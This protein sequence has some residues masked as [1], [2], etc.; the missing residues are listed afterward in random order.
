MGK[1]ISIVNQKGGVGKTITSINLA[2]A[3][4]AIEKKT[5]IIDADPQGNATTGIAIHKKDEN[6]LYTIIIENDSVEDAII[7]SS[8]EFLDILPSHIDL[9]A[10]EMELVNINNF[11]YR[12]RDKIRSVVDKY[13]YIIID[14][15]PSLGLL[16]INALTASD[17]VIIPLQ[18]EF[19]ALEGLKHLM[20]TIKMVKTNLNRDL[21]I[22]GVLLTMYDKR[23]NL[24]EQVEEDVRSC[25]GDLVYTT[26]IP[27]NVKMSEASSY[28]KPAL[29]YDMHCA[30]SKAY[31]EM[32]KEFL[33]REKIKT[34]ERI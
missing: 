28:G 1:V 26:I 30:G 16:T 19:F 23:N 29:V 11:R 14:C 15:P 33:N 34:G 20:E 25:L 24:T 3:L 5:L 13:D 31:L 2:T 12:L 4:A 22:G 32:A 10:A 18:C 27:R 21:S 7:N 8:I 9:A 6:N 17:S